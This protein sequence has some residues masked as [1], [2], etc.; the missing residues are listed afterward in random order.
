MQMQQEE[1]RKSKTE[2]EHAPQPPAGPRDP[3]RGKY[4]AVDFPDAPGAVISARALD[5]AWPKSGR[6][7]CCPHTIYFVCVLRAET[8]NKAQANAARWRPGFYLSALRVCVPQCVTCALV[9][10]HARL[11][12]RAV[13]THHALFRAYCNSC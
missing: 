12:T 13:G 1:T 7:T 3:G 2:M 10:T 11:A 4:H 8:R 5:G 9:W 6:H